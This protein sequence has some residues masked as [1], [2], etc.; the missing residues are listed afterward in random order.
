MVTPCE[1]QP[2]TC[3]YLLTDLTT[4][5]T[6]TLFSKSLLAKPKVQHHYMQAIERNKEIPRI[7]PS[8]SPSSYHTLSYS[9][10]SIL[11]TEML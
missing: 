1:T 11:F 7:D 9:D 2:L 10:L 4:Q 5:F 8:I 6:L 3:Q